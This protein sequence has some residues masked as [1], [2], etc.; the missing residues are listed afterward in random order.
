MRALRSS[1][2]MGGIVAA[3]LLL[4]LLPGPASGRPNIRTSFFALYTS[5]VGSRLDNLPSISGHCGVCHFRFTGGGP[6]NWY[7]QALE[8]ELPSH[9]N[10]DAGRQAAMVAIQNGDADNDSY[11]QLTEITDL[12]TY[13]NTPTFPG[14]AIGDLSAIS[15]VDVNDILAYLTPTTGSDTTPPTATLTAPN[16]GQM[17]TGGQPNTVTWTA[18]D[19]VIVTTVDLYY[20]DGEAEPW[21]LIAKSHAN[22][23]TFNWFVPNTPTTTARVRVVARDAVGNTGEDLSD[24]TFTILAQPGGIVPTTLRDFKQPGTQPLEGGPHDTSGVCVTCHGGYNAAVE[25]GH[26]WQG[27]MMGQAARDPLFYACV[28]IAEQDAPSSGDICIR[29]HTPSGWLGGRSTPTNGSGIT[30]T[31]RDGVACDDCH[32]MVDPIYKDGVSPPE[33][34][35]LLSGM[36]PSHVPTTYANGQFVIDF[37]P[38]KRGPFSDALALHPVLTSAF[39]RT[40]EFCGTCHDVSNPVFDRVSGPDYAPGPLDTEASAIASDVNMPLERTYSEWKNSSYPSGV[41]APEFAGNKADGIVSTCQDCHMRD[42]SGKGCNDGAVVTRPDLPLHDMTGGNYWMPNVIASLYPTETDAAALADAAS[43][44]EAMLQKAA[45]L[46]LALQAV[47]DSYDV[48]VTVTNRTG[49][50][51]P[52]GYPEGRRMWLHVLARDIGGK[53]VYES[54]AYDAATGIL[55]MT[56]PPV[57]YEAEL[58]ISPALAE[59]L[60]PG[61]TIG[62]PRGPSFHFAL[63][64]SVYKDTRV[65]PLGFTNAGFLTFGGT[66]VD[67]EHPG[68]GPRYADGQNWDTSTFTMPASAVRVWVELL[69][70]TTSRDYILFLRDENTTSTAG[71][72]LY[73]AWIINGRAAPVVMEADSMVLNPTAVATGESPGPTVRRV[74]VLSNPFDRALPIALELSRPAPVAMDVYDVRGRRVSHR[75]LGTLGGGP[76]RL[77]WEGRDDAGRPAGAGIYWVSLQVG[78]RRI[79]KQVVRIK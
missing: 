40:S 48:H 14:L 1:S 79:V 49:H 23:G 76:H 63:N 4:T 20:R 47:A 62:L 16:G 13:T 54:G 10:T 19:N 67:P 25:P 61:G 60:D 52:T 65:P 12:A 45:V 15:D 28:A 64:D 30:S 73:D 58:G 77:V 32:R 44:A 24:A 38:R 53:V 42:V 35:S 34:Q 6:R 75:S 78:E 59:A 31:D 36:I 37:N 66:P 17:W 22:S 57:V 71:D 50:K 69:Y 29:C 21:A 39:H 72:D 43:R 8:A 55:S 18:T 11:T 33:D 70:Q 5:A 2:W 46:G 68:P 74:S 7:G 27:T 3:A 41:Y 56:P 9:P 26:N 51:L